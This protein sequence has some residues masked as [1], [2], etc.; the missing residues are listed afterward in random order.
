MRKQLSL[1]AHTLDSVL[2]FLGLLALFMFMATITG[3][4]LFGGR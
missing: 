1:M 2:T 4:H 3:M